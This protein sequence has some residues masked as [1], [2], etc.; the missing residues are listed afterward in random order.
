MSCTGMA[1]IVKTVLR[2]STGWLERQKTIQQIQYQSWGKCFQICA[3]LLWITVWSSQRQP[4]FW[5]KDG[6]QKE[7]LTP[8]EW[9]SGRVAGCPLSSLRS[10]TSFLGP[11]TLSPRY[12]WQEW[13]ALGAQM[14][15]Q[16]CIKWDLLQPAQV[17]SSG[18]KVVCH[19]LV[20]GQRQP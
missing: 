16:F 7:G 9:M 2:E 1:E 17:F 15:L 4:W 5:E 13:E 19:C 20:F 10:F 3:Q 18:W 11:H 6:A 12:S 14:E 8:T